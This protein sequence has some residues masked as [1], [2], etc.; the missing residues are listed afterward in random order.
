MAK[1]FLKECPE[2][3]PSLTSSGESVMLPWPAEALK[4]LGK[5]YRPKDRNI[6]FVAVVPYR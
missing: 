2:L 6:P 1:R 3:L 4:H 5:D